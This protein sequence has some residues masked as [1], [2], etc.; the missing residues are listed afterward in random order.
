MI[1]RTAFLLIALAVV[2]MMGPGAPLVAQ[3]ETQSKTYSA[4]ILPTIADTAGVLL[5]IPAA[6][7]TIKIHRLLL[8]YDNAANTNPAYIGIVTA[9]QAHTRALWFGK[10][11]T[12]AGFDVFTYEP[13][14]RIA[15]S[16]AQGGVRM[17]ISA[18]ASD[19]LEA[20][21]EYEIIFDN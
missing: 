2:L 13:E 17:F 16:T 8:W 4:V 9:N 18:A 21:V 1:K 7:R 11:M 15:A 14:A 20:I 5:Q 10:A 3:Q 6:G 19:T 12:S